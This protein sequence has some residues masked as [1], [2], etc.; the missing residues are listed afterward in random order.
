MSGVRALL[1]RE[2]TAADEALARAC[3]LL[4]QHVPSDLADPIRYALAGGGKRLRPVLCVTAWRAL[5]GAAPDQPA[6]IHDLAAA[7]EIIHTYSLVHDD[8]PSMDDDALR[9]GRPTT[10]RVF[11]ERAATVAGAL[12]VPLAFAQLARAAAVLGLSPATRAALA[13]ELAVGAGAAGMVGG[14]WLD[15]EAEGMGL[16]LAQLETIHRRKTGALIAAALAMGA[17]AAGA[18]D[19]VVTACRDA[20]A[21]LGLAF[22][23]QDDVLDET[24][25]AAV[26][27]K[28]AGKDRDHGKA[29]FPA[30]LGLEQA[31][32]SAGAATSRAHA[33]LEAE[34][35]RD[36]MLHGLIGFAVERDR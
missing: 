29:T 27:G 16:S 34:G 19:A 4:L 5:R 31:R 22:Q 8:L 26:L 3:D 28:A 32:A 9:R 18:P 17:I 10:H 12:M 25:T 14:Q 6:A 13:C 36:E 21:A 23:I 7:I 35:V 15:L 30:L 11:G 20:G 2:R 24:A 1:E 33:A